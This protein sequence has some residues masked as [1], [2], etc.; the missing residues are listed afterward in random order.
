MS[1]RSRA[2][3]RRTVW[4]RSLLFEAAIVPG[5]TIARPVVDAGVNPELD[6]S[7]LTR[8]VG[9][10]FIRATD[11]GAAI[12]MQYAMGLF[13]ATAEAVGIGVAALPDPGAAAKAD[14]LYWV[15]GQL[16]FVGATDNASANVYQMHK[17]LDLH[18]Q[19]K[20]GQN[21]R[22]LTLL[23]T[24]DSAVNMVVSFGLNVL[25]KLA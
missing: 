2:P 3:R 18:S 8:T 7:T 6:G 14:W 20:L 23:I 15:G 13:L 5:A 22:D 10:V 16:L 12:P 9:D 1:T 17:A 24:N 4:S 25:F 21:N 11:S 19:R